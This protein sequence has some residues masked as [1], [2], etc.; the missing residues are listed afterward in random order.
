MSK[1]V[2]QG[3]LGDMLE[4]DKTMD[5]NAIFEATPALDTPI[6]EP[7]V[8]DDDDKKD[9]KSLKN[10]KDDLSLQNINKVLDKQSTTIAA[11]KKKVD[12]IVDVDDDDTKGK[13]DKAPASLNKSTDDEPSSDAP[14]TVIFARDLVTQGL[15]SSLDE[16]KFSEDVKKVGEAEALRNLIKGEIDLN[17]TA[18]K[19]DLDEGYQEYLNLVGKGVQPETAGDLLSLK[20]RFEKIKPA[21]LES[22]DNAELRKQVLTD[23]YKLTTSMS[24]AKIEKLVKTSVDLGDDIEDSKENLNTIKQLIKDQLA[25]EEQT[26]TE[27]QA[28]QRDEIKRTT[29]T[30]RDNINALDEILPGVGINKQTKV[31]MFDAIT[32]SV[33]DKQGRATNALWAKRSEDP[34]FFD[35]RL[36]YL[37]ET[38]F[39]EKGKAWSKAAQSKLTKQ[40]TDLE[41][42]IQSK[43]SSTGT[44]TIRTPEY[45][46]P[47]VKSKIDEM[48]GLFGT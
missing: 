30:L 31:K 21:D 4:Y 3:D 33:N 1:E 43:S 44:P 2:F 7:K 11:D 5:I 38:G 24:D 35:M 40:V 37:L 32:K 15:L 46:D 22:E 9:K 25:Q 10:D 20:D 47:T 6:D 34:M 26:A 13:D 39:F 36:S 41:K 14:F 12:D 23:Y 8:D 18:A 29:D 19:N 28:A 48:R 17:I 16:D 27:R 45:L 42:A